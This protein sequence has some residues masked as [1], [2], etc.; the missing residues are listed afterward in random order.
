SDDDNIDGNSDDSDS[1]D[2]GIQDGQN[3]GHENGTP[4]SSR[5]HGHANG[6]DGESRQEE[7]KREVANKKSEKRKGRGLMQWKP[8]R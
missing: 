3:A 8:V 5:S 7:K 2:L 1:D 6:A 4:R